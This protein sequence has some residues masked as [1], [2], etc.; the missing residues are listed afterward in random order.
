MTSAAVMRPPGQGGMDLMAPPKPASMG[1]VDS[2]VRPGQ[3]PAMNAV[4][5]ARGGAMAD[6]GIGGSIPPWATDPTKAALA[7]YR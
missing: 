2:G 1:P 6:A 7:G 4:Q 3:A 5:A